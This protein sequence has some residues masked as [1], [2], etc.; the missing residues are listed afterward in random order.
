MFIRQSEARFL[1]R[2]F[3]AQQ[4]NY[5]I[6]PFTDYDIPEAME[7]K[8]ALGWNQTVADWK[9]FIYL[10]G[11][12]CFKVV[13]DNHLAATCFLFIRD[14]IAWLAMVIVKEE[15]K[16]RGIGRA[17]ME[18]SLEYCKDR[19]ITLI[20]LDG[21]REA[22]PLYRGFGFLD[23]GELGMFKGRIGG[24]N[25]ARPHTPGL[26][27]KQVSVKDFDGIISIDTEAFGVSRATMIERLLLDYPE[28]GFVAGEKE[29]SGY[30][31]FKPGHHSYQIGPFVA[32]SPREANALLEAT[33]ERIG[34]ENREADICIFSP[35]NYQAAARLFER[36]GFTCV[37]RLIR[38]YKG[39]NMLRGRAEM[40]YALSGPEKG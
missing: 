24:L 31:L 33:I 30:I 35:L 25:Y 22:Y 27:L 8:N 16:R 19:G 6:L 18:K 2:R 1:E 13:I 4:V 37:R 21:T 7:L 32:S 29:I 23:E 11:G 20:K 5:K 15:Y 14:H 39:K 28:R 9:R 26:K 17:L 40:L 12:G 34:M 10:A 36:K 3:C 38:M